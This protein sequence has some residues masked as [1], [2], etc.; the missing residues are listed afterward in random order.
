MIGIIGAMPEEIEK[1]LLLMEES[2]A[3][4]HATRT[5]Y[6]GT[7]NNHYV[8]VV[9]AGIG[10]VNAAI[11]TTLLLE[12]FDVDAV[13]NIGV[14]GGQRGVKH[15]DVVV[16]KSVL[17]HDVDVTYFGTYQMGQLPGEEPEFEADETL[18]KAAIDVLDSLEISYKVGRIASGDKFVYDVDMVY[19]INQVYDDIYAIEMEAAAI[20]HTCHLYQVPFIIFRSISDVLGEKSQQEDF[21]SFLTKASE[22]VTTLLVALLDQV[23]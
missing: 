14:A 5:F 12:Q 17:Y 11:T 3:V 19:D 7:I 9:L 2:S 15:L 20:G 21:Q 8:V 4:E 22:Q 10:K 18:L 23:E 1:V 6:Q 13:I 16:S